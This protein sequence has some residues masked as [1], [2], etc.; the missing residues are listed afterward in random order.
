MEEQQLT[1]E[2]RTTAIRY[3]IQ[4]TNIRMKKND[5][6]WESALGDAF[7][8]DPHLGEKMGAWNAATKE[9]WSAVFR[10]V[11]ERLLQAELR[12]MDCGYDVA[13]EG[14]CTE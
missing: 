4:M 11:V 9:E 8:N 6:A 7:Q 14:I 1:T 13:R 2:Q 5:E 3:A 12:L 10:R